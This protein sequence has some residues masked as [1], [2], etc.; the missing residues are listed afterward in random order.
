MAGSPIYSD[1]NRKLGHHHVVITI[2]IIIIDTIIKETEAIG[3]KDCRDR[4]RSGQ[5]R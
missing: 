5:F 2:V 4:E 1:R 3:K